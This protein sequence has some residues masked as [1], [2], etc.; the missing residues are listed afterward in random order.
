MP[1]LEIAGL[2]SNK[3]LFLGNSPEVLISPKTT[4]PR[5]NHDL[6]RT[7]LINLIDQRHELV[8]LAELISWHASV[9]K[10][11][12]QFVYATVRPALPTRLM[13]ATLYIK[14]VCALSNEASVRHLGVC[15]IGYSD[16]QH[17]C[18]RGQPN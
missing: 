10:W 15:A 12:A 13:A 14:H 4:D 11:R 1:M 7:E 17:R 2:G 8:Q 16:H 6:F 9:D 5:N 3:H 18:K